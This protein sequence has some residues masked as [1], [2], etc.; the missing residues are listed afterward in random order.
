MNVKIRKD[1]NS[2]YNLSVIIIY[3]TLLKSYLNIFNLLT[4]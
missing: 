2:L 1:F 4:A 3:W